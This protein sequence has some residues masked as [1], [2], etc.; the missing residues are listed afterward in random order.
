M[1]IRPLRLAMIPVLMFGFGFLLVPLYDVFCDITGLNGKTGR[2]EASEIDLSTV[3][4]SRTIEVRF[5]AV[6]HPG[7]PWSFEPVQK[8]M[9]VHPGQIY[10]ATY[11]VR[12]TSGK[13]TLGQAV[14]SVSPGLAAGHFNKTE[15]FCFVQ[16]TLAAYEE[17]DMPMQFVIGPEI[18]NKIEEITLSYTFFSLDKS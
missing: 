3:D 16:Q 9:E 6:T 8:K 17:R 7:L 11:R 12:S 15:C 1:K 13:E 2:I 4:Q 18:S 10:E 5:L 14:P